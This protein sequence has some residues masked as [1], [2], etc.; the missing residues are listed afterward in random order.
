MRSR[1][2][3]RRGAEPAENPA[4]TETNDVVQPVATA[5]RDGTLDA[6]E[7]SLGPRLLPLVLLLGCAP[8]PDDDAVRDSTADDSGVDS[9]SDTDQPV[10]TGPR[11]LLHRLDAST[12]RRSV[13]DL[14]FLDSLPQVALAP[15][16]TIASFDH[17][18]EGLALTPLHLELYDHAIH[19]LLSPLA[20]ASHPSWARLLD[21]DP[22]EPTCREAA[23]GRFA[24]RA[25]R[26][27]VTA[28]ETARLADFATEAI[29][30]GAAP[31]EAVLDALSAV[32]TSPGFLFRIEQYGVV[33]DEPVDAWELASRMAF[34]LWK[35]LPDDALRADA[36]TGDLLDPAVRDAHVRRMLADPRAQA[37]TDDFAGQWLEIR[38]L[39]DARPEHS[40]FPAYDLD[41]RNRRKEAIR[42]DLAWRFEEALGADAPV[43]DL[44]RGNT[45]LVDPVLAPLYGLSMPAG[46]PP[47]V[48]ALPPQRN[49]GWLTSAGW[50]IVTSKVA[51]TSPTRRGKWI[52][53]RLFCAP[54][55]APPPGVDSFPPE[56]VDLD[57]STIRAAIEFLTKAPDCQACHGKTDPYGFAFEQF[58]H[59]G[60]WGLAQDG[61]VV[62]VEVTLPTGE[63]VTGANAVADI[64]ADDPRIPGC[65]VEYATTYALGRRAPQ[66][67]VDAVLDE[68]E[69]SGAPLATTFERIVATPWFSTR[70][71]AP[72]EEAR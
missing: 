69:A 47:S 1:P 36:A 51:R 55:S 70:V 9:P 46:S 30:A 52:R 61:G 2:S 72:D 58:S 6:E 43:A 35:S 39:E 62:D 32:L 16:P 8:A 38:A 5:R 15:D 21:C 27:P 34:F 57:L 60:V 49:G 59:A 14:L 26:R 67:A 29:T 64:V 33:D 44:F 56:L 41:L 42:A 23:L 37:L 10:D 65:F 71:P 53:E 19:A 28:E 50:L 3:T 66:E 18:L 63:H 31:H 45:A 11:K 25:W 4:D 12:W 48:R 40:L 54:P 17:L 20:E 13:R 7:G 24:S 22:V 68:V